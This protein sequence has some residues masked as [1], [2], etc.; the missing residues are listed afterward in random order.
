MPHK[1]H[2]YAKA[3]DME[4]ATLC[5]YSQ[6]DYALPNQKFVIQCCFKCSSINLPDQ[7]TDD[8]YP[9]T[10]P[11]IRFHIYHIIARCTKHVRFPLT[12]KKNCCKFQQDPALGQSIKI[13]TIKEL[14]MM[15]KLFQISIQVFI[16][17]KFRNW[18]FTFHTYKYWVRITVVDLV[19]LRLNAENHFKMCYVTVIIIRGQLLVF[20]TRYNQNIMV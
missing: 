18:C 17:H 8:Q 14:V 7:E 5:S 1:R 15:E 4:K 6:S 2:I 3:Y 10:I 13:N 20:P 19:G 9:D 16:F 11:S 12:D